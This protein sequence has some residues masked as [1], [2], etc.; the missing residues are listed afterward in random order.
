MKPTHLPAET[1]VAK[2]NDLKQTDKEKKKLQLPYNGTKQR[3]RKIRRMLCKE[4]V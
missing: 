4:G 3:M 1:I 2:D